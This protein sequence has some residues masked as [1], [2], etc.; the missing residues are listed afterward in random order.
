MRESSR[1]EGGV[2][3][4]VIEEGG[5]MVRTLERLGK[6]GV[7]LPCAGNLTRHFVFQSSFSKK[8]KKKECF[9]WEQT[10]AWDCARMHIHLTFLSHTSACTRTNMNTQTH[11][12]TRFLALSGASIHHIHTCP[13]SFQVSTT[14]FKSHYWMCFIWSLFFWCPK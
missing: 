13:M 5:G 12:Y 4:V 1:R 11:T 9:C 6:A 10:E 3:V 8:K 14:H 7:R 2:V